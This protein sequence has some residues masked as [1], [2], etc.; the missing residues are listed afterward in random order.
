[1]SALR[2]GGT[3]ALVGFDGNYLPWAAKMLLDPARQKEML[4][5]LTTLGKGLAGTNMML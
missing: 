5:K 2:G 3:M 1:M 4:E